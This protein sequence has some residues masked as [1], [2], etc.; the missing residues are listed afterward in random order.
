MPLSKRALAALA[1][2]LAVIAG[3]GILIIDPADDQVAPATITVPVDGPDVDRKA[4]DP[5]IAG[6][7]APAVLDAAIDAPEKFDLGDDLRGADNTSEG[8][9]EGPLAAPNWPGCS[10]RF[11]PVNFSARTNTIKGFAPHYTGSKNIAGWADMN[12][13]AAYAA[14]RSAGVSWHFLIDREGHCYYQVP[15][16]QKAWTIGNLNSETIN[17]EVIGTGSEPDYA[18]TAGFAKLAAIIRRAGSIYGFPMRLGAVSNCRFTRSG[19]ITHWMGGA[20]AGGHVDIKPYD[21]AALARRVASGNIT[22][23]D[24]VTCRKLN[25]WRKAGSPKGGDWERNSVRRKA[26][27]TRRGVTCTNSGPVR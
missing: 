14:S 11:T 26:A 18:G 15:V 1:A 24:R 20:C 23:T 27:L 21:I 4:D 19:I 7:Q 5:I 22:A 17:A 12:G 8:V 9:I 10:T 13:L 6:G 16:N 2:L 3:G 25:A